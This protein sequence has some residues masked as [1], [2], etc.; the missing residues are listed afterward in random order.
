MAAFP[1]RKGDALVHSPTPPQ[2]T[3]HPVQT[4]F[5]GHFTLDEWNCVCCHDF[6]I[7]LGFVVVQWPVFLVFHFF[8]EMT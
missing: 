6:V 1:Q 7:L 4:N 8:G 3:A 5:L 2:R